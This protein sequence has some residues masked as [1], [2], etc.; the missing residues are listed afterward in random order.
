MIKINTM[1]YEYTFTP[2]LKINKK[3]E[4]KSKTYNVM[5]QSNMTWYTITFSCIK[6]NVC[7]CN[8]VIAIYTYLLMKWNK[9]MLLFLSTMCRIRFGSH[10]CKMYISIQGVSLFSEYYSFLALYCIFFILKNFSFVRFVALCYAFEDFI[11]LYRAFS[12]KKIYS[13]LHFLRFFF[14]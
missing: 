8:I 3:N 14:F 11:T 5:K 9:K 2:L 7:N 10:L 6:T 12:K 4:S 13:F 1:L